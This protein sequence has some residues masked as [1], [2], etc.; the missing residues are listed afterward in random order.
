MPIG[1]HNDA[2]KAYQSVKKLA[3]KSANPVLARLTADILL[4]FVKNIRQIN[5]TFMLDNLPDDSTEYESQKL[6]NAL[7]SVESLCGKCRENHD[8]A[9]FVNQ[10]RRILIFAK[11]GIDLGS[12]FDGAKSLAQLLEDA[13]S[14]GSS[15]KKIC[16]DQ[17]NLC[18]E[19]VTPEAYAEL[20]R[21]YEELRDKDVF[22]GTL[23]DE[24]VDT[25]KSVSE[26]NLEAEMPV[27]DDHQL[28]K[29]ATAFNIML[30]TINRSMSYLDHLVAE[31]VADLNLANQKLQESLEKLQKE[32]EE[33]ERLEESLRETNEKIMESI[34][35]AKM[36]QNAL[37]PNLDKI[38]TY[39][40]ESFFLWMPRDVVGGDIFFAESVEDG[41]VIAVIDCTG[42]GVPGAFLTM[43]AYTGLRRII[44]SEE[45][46]D[47]AQILK[48]LNTIVKKT[49]RQ[50]TEDS[51]SDDGLDAA[52]VR[53]QLSGVR[54]QESEVSQQPNT[55]S[56]TP[57]TNSQQQLTFAGAKLPLLIVHNGEVE[58]I[59]GD[60]QSLGYKRSDLD[61]NFTTH[62]VAIEK[63]ISFYMYTDG[64][65][66]QM[67]GPGDRRF[68]ST[69][70]KEL[71]KNVAVKPFDEQRKKLV[72]AFEAYRGENET[73]DDVTV[74][75][76]GF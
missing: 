1:S 23:I 61:F 63:G 40:P 13:F 56:Q 22:R 41:F 51:L 33:R 25:I 43:I 11:T 66:D 39:L 31:R 62:K 73:Q 75:G 26:G 67:G 7:E 53:V 50:D 72:E 16:Q 19:E 2:F 34:H 17:D 74:V 52:I 70:F 21:K 29:L 15:D 32:I 60:R 5:P 37:L 3:G 18:K 14:S 36:I 27:H 24:I 68:G 10:S 48:R 58:I 54:S 69:Q 76:F 35:Y 28:G 55:N 4:D 47:P 9:C 38:K 46:Y 12:E 44:I 71:L 42:H 20:K 57:I 6:D 30:K 49:L 59:K 65:A 8:N 45:C 64:F